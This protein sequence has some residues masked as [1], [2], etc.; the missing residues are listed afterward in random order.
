M[1]LQR[2]TGQTLQDYAQDFQYAERKLKSSHSIDLPEK[3]RAWWYLRRSGVT[4]EQRQL[5]MT[6]LGESG[7]TLDK[8]MK[9]MNFILGQDTKQEGSS[10]WN[11]GATEYRA[12]AYYA[13]E[14][15]DEID[16]DSAYWEEE[17]DEESEAYYAWTEEEEA[18]LAGDDSGDYDTEE[19]DEVYSAYVDAKQHLNRLRTSR[20]FYPVVAMV[21]GPHHPREGGPGKGRG[22]KSGGK[23][24][25]R[26]KSKSS[27]GGRQARDPKGRGRDALG[28]MI[29]LRCG[30]AGHR[31]KNCP[32][33]SSSSDKKRKVEAED[34]NVM[35]VQNF[36][37]SDDDF[38]TDSDDI[39]VQDQGAAS[40]LGSKRQ[41]RRYLKCLMEHGVDIN[42]EVN[43]YYCSKGFRFGNSQRE[44][45]EVCCL[46]PIYVGGVKRKILCYVIDGTAPILFGRPVMERLGMAVD[47]S[48]KKV[49]YG[50]DLAWENA[51]MGKKGEYVIR[52]TKDI[53]TCMTAPVA[54]VLLPQDFR[55]H[56]DIYNKLPLTTITAGGPLEFSTPTDPVS[57]AEFLEENEAEAMPDGAHFVQYGQE[58]AEESEQ[59]TGDEVLE[60][61]DDTPFRRVPVPE[62][63]PIPSPTPTPTPERGDE[64]PTSPGDEPNEKIT[65]PLISTTPSP[66]PSPET[67]PREQQQSPRSS[68]QSSAESMREMRKLK[69]HQL[70]QMV[71]E[72]TK[73]KKD[74]EVMLAE[75]KEPQPKP[76]VIWELYA[77]M[78]RITQKVNDLRKQGFNVKA[79]KFSLATG[80]D[81]SKR[82]DQLKLL[83]RLR[84]E[85]PDEV[86]MSPEC[87][88]WSSLQEL[89]AAKSA[90][91]REK[92][93]VRR[94][95]NHDTHLTFTAVIY[96]HQ[97]KSYRHAHIEH[98]WTS[99]AW[100]TKAW[101]KLNGWPTRLDQCMLGLELENDDGVLLPV[102]K[103]T[104]IH[105]TKKKMHTRM[106][107]FR[108]DGTHHHTPL[109]GY[110]RGQ[111]PRAKLAENYPEYMAKV[112]AEVLINHTEDEDEILAAQDQQLQEQDY[113]PEEDDEPDAAE[114]LPAGG[115]QLHDQGQVALQ[116]RS[117]DARTVIRANQELKKQVGIRAVDY[118]AR[119]HKNL[120]H[121]GKEVLVAMLKDVL[122][123]EDVILAAKHYVCP[124]CYER[125]KPGQ[126]PPAAGRSSAV[127]N[128]R[129]QCDSSWIQVEEGRRCVLT[130]CDEATR[131]VALRLL[132]SEKST[133][134]L[135]GLERAWI[136]HFGLPK[137]IRVDPAKGWSAEA[138]RE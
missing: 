67:S 48:N 20:G 26:G 2:K 97:W 107:E 99:R 132:K 133:E 93:I 21:Q 42:K 33:E 66:K 43:V 11:R 102:K 116:D 134:F 78:G 24:G 32:K 46:M 95:Q 96:R 64:S 130:I 111:G 12:Q 90:E 115:A 17:W 59:R 104:C 108:C 39:A 80:W 8:T 69:P 68:P 127:F 128:H 38:D 88:L 118:V 106:S 23:G 34:S 60:Q 10:R 135:K 4:K 92:L 98:P 113:T 74:L 79:E 36:D 81:F 120:G 40:V 7:L 122:A 61:E 54:E 91:A 55:S 52:L 16:E 73:M 109:E 25:K 57:T 125:Q 45:T 70:R 13:G 63:E 89:A 114:G 131:F 35:M 27:K 15:L 62:P 94:Q 22:K 29:C 110:I 101:S 14:E 19:F 117:E 84:D 9:A 75:A 100:S 119:L 71:F 51:L 126:A 82:S 65:D 87:K 1:K 31:A 136:R 121:P 138:I 124:R 37:I 72:N 112:I 18:Y 103:A 47:F 56:I 3:V 123:T 137:I 77:G 50:S 44:T 30:Q 76:Y 85:E 28:S 41:L 129:L 53:D 6:Q 86:F 105:T 58:E 5:V 83:R 49:R